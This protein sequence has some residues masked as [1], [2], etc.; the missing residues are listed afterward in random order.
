MENFLKS[1][2]SSCMLMNSPKNEILSLKSDHWRLESSPP[3]SLV[4]AA[5][6]THVEYPRA[7]WDR[8]WWLIEGLLSLW[9][10][11][12][13]PTTVVTWTSR[14][15]IQSPIDYSLQSIPLFFSLFNRY[16]TKLFFF[17]IFFTIENI[18]VL[19]SSLFSLRKFS[20]HI[21]I[22]SSVVLLIFYQAHI[23]WRNYHQFRKITSSTE[24]IPELFEKCIF[25]EWLPSEDCLPDQKCSSCS[26]HFRWAAERRKR[27]W[28]TIRTIVYLR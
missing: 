24:I 11:K 12:L 8:R 3:H 21:F 5:P 2:S 28:H 17:Y 4:A 6:S 20:I 18:F 26:E 13:I 27:T 25:S 15:R 16:D 7:P 9:R 23:F 1:P 10:L 19:F 14:K 22:F